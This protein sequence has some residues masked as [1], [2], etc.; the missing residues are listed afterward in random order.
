MRSPVPIHVDAKV[1]LRLAVGRAV[2]I[3]QIEV[4]NAVVESRAQ[5]ALL[6]AEG[7]DIAEVVPQPQGYGGQLQATV[8]AAAVPHVFIAIPG[9]NIDH[10]SIPLS[11]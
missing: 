9:G 1:G 3:R 11:V 6:H 2:V 8:A 10:G 5:E 4:R 7:R